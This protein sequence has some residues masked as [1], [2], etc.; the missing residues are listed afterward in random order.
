MPTH[1]PGDIAKMLLL[2]L[3]LKRR[4]AAPVLACDAPGN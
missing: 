3:K 1:A 4:P 2:L